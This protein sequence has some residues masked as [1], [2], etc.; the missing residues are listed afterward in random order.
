MLTPILAPII[1]NVS[2]KLL[3]LSA[4]KTPRT[5]PNMDAKTMANKVSSI[6]IGS[7]SEMMR[8]TGLRSFS[9]VPKSPLHKIAAYNE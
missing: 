7:R 3:R 1:V 8:T 6:V 9:E 5:T 4:E 2:M